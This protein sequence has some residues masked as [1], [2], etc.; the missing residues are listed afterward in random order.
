M[1][2][3]QRIEYRPFPPG[4]RFTTGAIRAGRQLALMHGLVDVDVTEARRWLR[5][6]DPHLSLTAYVGACVARAAARFPEV[7]AYRDWRGRL[8][9]THDV[10][11][12]VLV[13]RDTVAGPVPVGHVLRAA[14]RR[15]VAELSGELRSVQEAPETSINDRR[16][17]RLARLARFPGVASLF[18]RAARRSVRLHLMGTVAV[19]SIGAFGAGGG[20]GIG[21]PTVLTLSVTVGGMS[22]Q[23]RVVQGRIQV[24][25][26]LN[27]T[28]SV[29]HNITDGAPAARFVAVLRELI[30]SP[31]LL[32][33]SRADV[34]T[35][36]RTAAAW[37]G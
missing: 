36:G 12:A 30:E 29:D 27:L 16:F 1:A 33:S 4:R 24:R 28:I 3:R 9:L 34:S 37:P 6:F 11:L 8:V 17:G 7:H 14:D 26:V 5:T 15:S 23:A 31:E 20:Y 19:S 10:D 13:E 18:F 21:V 32:E 35:T 2:A 25:E 22:E